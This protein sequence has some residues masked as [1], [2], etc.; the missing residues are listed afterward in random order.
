[1]TAANRL[2]AADL[3]AAP[4]LIVMMAFP[5]TPMFEPSSRH[6]QNIEAGFVAMSDL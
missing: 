5:R 3:L 6:L 2:R 1:M 4:I